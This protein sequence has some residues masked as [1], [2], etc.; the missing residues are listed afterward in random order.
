MKQDAETSLLTAVSEESNG[1]STKLLSLLALATGA[2]AM[3]QTS[4][5]D[6]IFTDLNHVVVGTN[7]TASFLIDNL[8]GTAR[9]IFRSNQRALPFSS[10][11]VS[12]AQAAGYIRFKT[13]S[14]FV[15]PLGV[16]VTWNGVPPPAVQSVNGI[17]GLLNKYG[18]SPNSFDHK[19]VLFTFK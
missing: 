19:Y 7:A 4:I 17:V 3:P 1:D 15:I 14:A 13:N 11:S 2:V 16:G 12:A 9:F 8:P 5:A 10:R 18:A 6:V